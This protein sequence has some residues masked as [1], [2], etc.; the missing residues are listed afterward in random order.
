MPVHPRACGEHVAAR[1]SRAVRRRF[2]P[3]RAGNTTTVRPAYGQF[4]GSSPRVRGTR[5]L[6]P[7]ARFIPRACG[8]HHRCGGHRRKHAVHP[9]VRGEHAT[10]HFA[11]IDRFIPARAG[12]HV[13]TVTKRRPVHPRARGEHSALMLGHDRTVHPR[14]R[15][16]HSWRCDRATAD[17]SVHPRARGNT[18]AREDA[19][20]RRSRFIPACA[21]N[22][23]RGPCRVPIGSSVH[24]RARGEHDCPRFSPSRP[25]H[26]RAWGTRFHT[27]RRQIAV[28]PRARGEHFRNS[29]S[30]GFRFIPARAGNTR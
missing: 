8:E 9:R 28:H 10:R 21:G 13:P 2:I 19:T 11:R 14:A 7:M 6:Q 12:E 3:A 30:A 18:L 4:N 17:T 5:C 27:R 25:V 20:S 23:V 22:T 16:E 15:G 26:P 24:P 1:R 29:R